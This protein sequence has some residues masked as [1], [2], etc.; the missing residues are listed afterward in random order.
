MRRSSTTIG[1]VPDV[2]ATA[3]KCLEELNTLLGKAIF[4][5]GVKEDDVKAVLAKPL[6]PRKEPGK[7]DDKS[8]AHHFSTTAVDAKTLS[9]YIHQTTPLSLLRYA[10]PHHLEVERA[11]LDANVRAVLEGYP[12]II[13]YLVADAYSQR[14]D[15]GTRSI[16]GLVNYVL[17]HSDG[18]RSVVDYAVVTAARELIDRE[19][20]EVPD[21]DDDGSA[22]V[23]TLKKA[24]LP[25]SAGAFEKSARAVIRQFISNKEEL[26]YIDDV[27][28]E[29]KLD[30]S[31]ALRRELVKYV[32][33]S[34]VKITDAN[35]K[36][37]IP[38]FISQIEEAT[39]VVE[40]PSDGDVD[41]ERAERDFD[42]HYFEDDRSLIQVSQSAVKCAAQLYYSMVVGDELDVFDV[43]NYF[44]HKYLIR[45]Q[46]EI[47]DPRLRDDLQMYVFSGEF[48]DL[49][50]KKTV[51]RTRPAERDMF[52]RQVF[53]SGGG[54][55]T[56]DVIVNREFSR[57]WKVLMLESA[58][59]LERAQ[60][61][62]NPH[63][64]VSKQNVMQAVEDLQYNLSTHCT[65]M[66][67]VISPLIY[68]ELDFVIKRIFM[69]SEVRKHV[70]PGGGTWWR[71]VEALH[72][73]MKH[74]RPKATVLYNKARL[75]HKIIRSIAEYDPATFE[76]NQHFSAFISDVDA[77]ITTQ[78]ILQEAL[79]DDLKSTD[80]DDEQ[81]A[82]N[83]AAADDQEMPPPAA[84][85]A[86]GGQ[87][88]WDF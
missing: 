64:F 74:A 41:L 55:V 35:A 49:E 15:A 75:G 67:T 57:L 1:A 12:A 40:E 72:M 24:G 62:P 82:V 2:D 33:A 48:I 85:A 61:S 5:A 58:R 68:A 39:A 29:L 23:A 46:I 56:D 44:T 54:A 77:F 28:K 22:V 76:S 8:L 26:K 32:K 71:V 51:D 13:D 19:H 21:A 18:V 53:N 10:F 87:D 63:S 52:Y 42:V 47:Q 86:A 80:E 30:L 36:Y 59:Y 17:R 79:T 66:A 69:H 43:V 65:G 27:A 11:T 16:E 88:E 78:S 9:D 45:G 20:L 25:L 70:A 38:L 34:P 6:T 60:L 83:G 4:A 73:G 37:F 84:T 3:R 7:W 81:A 31:D 50:T 14:K